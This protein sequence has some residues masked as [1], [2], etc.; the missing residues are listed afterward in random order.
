MNTGVWEKIKDQVW[1]IGNL[2]EYMLI[3]NRINKTLVEIENQQINVRSKELE[4]IR[5]LWILHQDLT[6]LHQAIQ[7]NGSYGKEYN[8]TDKI[9]PNYQET[10]VKLISQLRNEVNEQCPDTFQWGD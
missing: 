1:F 10:I 4:G 8:H 2:E 7:A 9:A 5:K 3:L 6:F